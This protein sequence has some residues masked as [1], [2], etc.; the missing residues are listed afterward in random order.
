VRLE[1]S[2]YIFTRLGFLVTCA[3]LLLIVS[4]TLVEGLEVSEYEFEI[5]DLDV[6]FR[7]DRTRYMMHIG[8]VKSTNHLEDRIHRTDM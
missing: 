6:S 7:V 1:A 2:I 5:D 8:V 4:D 3:D